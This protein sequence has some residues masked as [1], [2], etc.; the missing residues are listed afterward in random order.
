MADKSEETS[1]IKTR[2]KPNRNSLNVINNKTN[3]ELIFTADLL[4]YYPRLTVFNKY[5]A[6]LTLNDASPL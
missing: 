4:K 1:C 5:D 2:H 6:N 3:I